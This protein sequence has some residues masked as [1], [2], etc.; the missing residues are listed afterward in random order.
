MFGVVADDTTG[1]NDIGVMFCKNNYLVKIVSFEKDMIIDAD[2]D[3]IIIDTDSRLDS[4]ERAY[5]KVFEATIL[6][7]RI[8]CQ[9]FHKKT[10]SV[11]RGNVGQEFDA[12]LDALQE[13]F[14]VV[15]L[16]FP[17]NGRKTIDG[18]HTVHG[19]LLEESEFAKD[20]VHPLCRSD[21]KG[22]L[23]YQS[24]RKVGLVSLDTVRMGITAT[25]EAI[26]EAKKT[27]NYC[28]VDGETQKDLTILAGAVKGFSVLAGSSGLAEE[29][30]KFAPPK[31]KVD[32][33]SK[34]D[35]ASDTNGVLV[36][37]GSLM[38]QTFQQTEYLITAG[39]PAKIL[40][41]RLIFDKDAQ[42]IQREEIIIDVCEHLIH[43]TDVLIMAE[44][45]PD[46]VSE[47][48][49]IGRSKGYDELTISKMVSA[50]LAE[51]AER[52]VVAVKLKRLVVAG[53][54][55]A[56]TVCRK[57][58]INGN[59]VLEEIETGLPSGLSIGRQMLIVLKSGSFGKREFLMKAI[60]H[61]KA[62][63]SENR[64]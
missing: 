32:L 28:I 64:G 12:M 31:S 33:L 2:A 14:M 11:F 30:P 5:Q 58:G 40:D 48:K 24:K 53:G 8:G 4:P 26:E 19:K 22:I 25:R 1:A 61:L 51:I 43:G 60:D 6:L 54:D 35:I 59:Y 20:P 42:E 37:S 41:A 47:T 16:A 62:I 50:E 23:E 44:N 3:V 63:S 34:Y 45:R 13:T 10:C 29:I 21:L 46:F 17:K 38:P 55:T 15:S 27:V 36:V 18:I 9:T 57:L 56:G 7:R 52:V 39:I 49:L